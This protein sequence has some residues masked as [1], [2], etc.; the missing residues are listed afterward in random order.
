MIDVCVWGLSRRDLFI[1]SPAG[2]W[3]TFFYS[4]MS[5]AW[6]DEGKSS[7]VSYRSLDFTLCCCLVAESGVFPPPSLRLQYICL[8]VCWVFTHSCFSIFILG[9]KTKK[10]FELKSPLTCPFWLQYSKCS[11]DGNMS[12]PPGQRPLLLWGDRM[13]KSGWIPSLL[14]RPSWHA[15][16]ASLSCFCEAVQTR[17]ILTEHL[18]FLYSR[19]RQP[20]T[21]YLGEN[22]DK[23]TSTARC[24]RPRKDLI[25]ILYCNILE[26]R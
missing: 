2:S 21:T 26:L 24:E 16:C 12:S 22:W 1:A 11:A 6:S 17:N 3:Q 18:Q 7:T 15:F 25:D 9:E 10:S 13:S 14:I 4:I 5:Q 23:H 19:S 20:I 8:C